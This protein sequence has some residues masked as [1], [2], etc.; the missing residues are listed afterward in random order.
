M[1]TD[2]SNNNPAQQPERFDEMTGGYDDVDHERAAAKI[3]AEAR[4]MDA[5]PRAGHTP[6][7]WRTSGGGVIAD[8]YGWKGAIIA[9]AGTITHKDLDNGMY[10]NLRG[11][12]NARLIAAAPDLL[13]ACRRAARFMRG[14]HTNIVSV[15]I[16]LGTLDKAIARATGGAK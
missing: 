9:P 15:D 13:E 12:A 5:T 6:G 16:M 1:R 8:S 14:D 3:R 4:A 2:D 10:D 11:E 7:P